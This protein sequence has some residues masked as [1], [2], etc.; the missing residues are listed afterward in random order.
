MT[1]GDVLATLPGVSEKDLPEVLYK[2]EDPNSPQAFVGAVQLAH[3]DVIHILLGRGLLDQDEAFVLGFTMG[4]CKEGAPRNQVSEMIEVL[5][6]QYPE[7]YRIPN[8]KSLAFELG[9]TCAESMSGCKNIFD[10]ALESEE[11]KKMSLGELR[12]LL[13]IDIDI[14]KNT[15]RKEAAQIPDSI[16]SARLPK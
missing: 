7:P 12:Q 10:V 2:Y 3:H 11:F 13:G 5:T 4:T 15:Y 1:L 6:S 16:E 14:L 9:V 8:Q